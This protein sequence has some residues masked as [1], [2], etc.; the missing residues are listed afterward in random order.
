VL[1]TSSG[2]LFESNSALLNELLKGLWQHS[3]ASA[4]CSRLL[5]LKLGMSQPEVLFTMG[6]LHDIG[7]LVLLRLID[8][9][10]RGMPREQ[11]MQV[12]MS[13]HTHAGA[14][15]LREWNFPIEIAD[16]ALH[17]HDPQIGGLSMMLRIVSFANQYVSMLG[18]SVLEIDEE[19][20]ESLIERSSLKIDQEWLGTLEEGVRETVTSLTNT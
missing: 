7:S 12:L 4:A 15:L 6:L 11:I 19:P 2:K 1:V 17:H 13:L 9:E 3:L 18:Y 14:A 20:I 16:A 5:G 10:F 8:K